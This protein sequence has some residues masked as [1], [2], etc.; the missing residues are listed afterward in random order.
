MVLTKLIKI[1]DKI[2]KS[3]NKIFIF[4]QTNIRKSIDKFSKVQIKLIILQAKLIIV[5]AKLIIC[6]GKNN[7][8]YR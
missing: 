5:Q 1:I 8:W 3:I 2:N 4:V 6:K 7:K